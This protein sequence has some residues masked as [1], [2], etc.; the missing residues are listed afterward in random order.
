MAGTAGTGGGDYGAG[1]AQAAIQ[2]GALINNIIQGN[3]SIKL[4]EQNLA[5]QKDVFAEEKKRYNTTLEN[6]RQ[7]IDSLASALSNM[8]QSLTI[9]PPP[10]PSP[11]LNAPSGQS[12]ST[13]TPPSAQ[14][15]TQKDRAPLP[16]Q[17][18]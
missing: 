11:S 2:T 18:D 8:N 5:H 7:G 14:T 6:Q 3:K 13:Q 4:A 16:T 15:Q 17:R 10:P 12:P 9:A 1:W